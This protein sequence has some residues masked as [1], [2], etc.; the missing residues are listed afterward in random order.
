VT[1]VTLPLLEEF[2]DANNENFVATLTYL[3]VILNRKGIL[4]GKEVRDIVQN[5]VEY[6]VNNATDQ[7]VVNVI[8]QLLET[9]SDD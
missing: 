7:Q 9:V 5:N 2:I 1:N 3:C 6:L 8:V 4:S